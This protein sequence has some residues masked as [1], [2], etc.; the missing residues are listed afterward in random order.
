M[1]PDFAVGDY[2]HVARVRQ[3]G[4]TPKFMNT[5]TGPWRVV[6]KTGGYVYGVEDIV[7]RHSREVHIA[8]MRPYADASLNVTAELK[9]V[10]SNLKSQGEFDIEKVEALDL[11]ADGEEYVVNVK[12]IG[13]DEEETTWEPM[14]TIYADAPKYV[15]AQLRK[16]RLTTEVRDHLKKTYVMKV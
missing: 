9:E 13:L 11:A 7:T 16:L 6:S 5:W 14:F 15:L 1:L 10:L 8:R 4:I 3:P 12:W 2:V